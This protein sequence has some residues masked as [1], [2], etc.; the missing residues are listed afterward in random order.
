MSPTVI[1]IGQTPTTI[2]CRYGVIGNTPDFH[3]GDSIVY[4]GSTPLI[5]TNF[6]W[7]HRLMVKDER[8]SISK[9][10]VRFPVRLPFHAA[11]VKLDWPHATNV[12]NES[13]YG[14]SS[15]LSSAISSGY[16]VTW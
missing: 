6:Q 16:S 5:D 4:R 13:S 1:G 12:L 3:S 7:P 14:G 8:L 10:W 2:S 11:V 15:P 9:S